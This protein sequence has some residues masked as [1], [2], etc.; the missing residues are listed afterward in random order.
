MRGERGRPRTEPDTANQHLACSLYKSKTASKKLH[1][2]H[3]PNFG[4]F[5]VVREM[6]AFP[7][8]SFRALALALALLAGSA[9]ASQNGVSQA[10]FAA[11][12]GGSVKAA[13]GCLSCSGCSDDVS[14]GA[15]LRRFR[16]L[17]WRCKRAGASAGGGERTCQTTYR[18]RV[19]EQAS[20]TRRKYRKAFA[21]FRSIS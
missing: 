19:P 9:A 8:R 18:Q 10:P 4:L 1:I 3:V 6:P 2:D 17:Q 5:D 13:D 11:A 14:R 15:V 21:A 12:A 20:C 7:S 16:R